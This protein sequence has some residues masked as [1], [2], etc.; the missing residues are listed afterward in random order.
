MGLI[1]LVPTPEQ[2]QVPPASGRP[3]SMLRS[4]YVAISYEFSAPELATLAL[5]HPGFDK[6]QN[7][8]RLEF[9][10][11]GVLE[12]IVMRERL[13]RIRNASVRTMNVVN[14]ASLAQIS[15][16]LQLPNY[17]HVPKHVAA[18]LRK[19][20]SGKEDSKTSKIKADLLEALVGAIFL[21][22]YGDLDLLDGL[23]V[24]WR[25]GW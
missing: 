14:N 3:G 17:A 2:Y 22:S 16:T 6:Q 11:D 23:L 12:W 9:L 13:L 4:L 19:N 24:T 21:D 1:G 5:T 7:Y 10:G 25:G 15:T 20:A 8:D 18:R